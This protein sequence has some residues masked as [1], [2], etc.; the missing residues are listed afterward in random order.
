MKLRII[1]HNGWY[2]VQ[3][4]II[5]WID[6]YMNGNGGGG[7]A[8]FKTPEEAESFVDDEMVVVIKEYG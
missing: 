1:K 3:V 5:F 7:L 6:Y 8:C 4:R 2:Q